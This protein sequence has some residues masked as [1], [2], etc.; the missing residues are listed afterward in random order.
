MTARGHLGHIGRLAAYF[1][2][3]L[4]FGLA[5]IVAASVLPRDPL[6]WV[7]WIVVAASALAAG[8]IVLAR[9]DGRP[10]GALGFPLRAAAVTEIAVG[11]ALG[12]VLL[13][14]AV[15]ALAVTGNVRFT[16]DAGGAGEYLGYLGATLGFF[17]VAAAAEELLF[18]GYAF[19]ALVAWI[20]VWPA[21]I[22]SSGVFAWMHGANP[23]IGP[24]AFAN[25]F[26]AG[27]MLAV[28]YLRTR[29]LWFATAVHTGW[30][31]MMASVLDLPVSGLQGFDTP[32][33]DSAAIGPVWWTGGGFGPEAGLAGS[34]V[35]LA[36]TVWLARTARLREPGDVRALRPLVDERLD[37][38][39]MVGVN[40]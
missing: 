32:L 7:G 21:V 28:A 6:G 13:G 23:G 19:Q 3:L 22:V 33:Y 14:A 35:L 1:G 18:R 9:F 2:L 15:A 12:A 4:A 11:L 30:N 38:N 31:W 17:W 34:A 10:F 29:S 36:G 39:E 24:V 40:G 37:P 5:G 16:A 25:I 8:W 27:V 26:L 20:G